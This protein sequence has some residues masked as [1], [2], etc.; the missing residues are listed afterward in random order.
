MSQ[1]QS[2]KRIFRCESE[3]ILLRERD[4]AKGVCAGHRIRE[5][6][7]GNLLDWLVVTW[8]KLTRQL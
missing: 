8:W 6:A 5:I 7:H 4:I 1:T 2:R 3:R